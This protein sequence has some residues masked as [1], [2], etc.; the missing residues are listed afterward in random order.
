MQA[1]GLRTRPASVAVLTFVVLVIV[2]PPALAAPGDIDSSF[3]T[4]G[5]V[6]TDFAGFFDIA[7]DALVQGNGRIVAVGSAVFVPQA[8]GQGGTRG[9]PGV[10]SDVAVA[11]YKPNGA[12]DPA[13]GGGDGLVTTDFGGAYDLGSA[14]AVLPS[15]AILV[16]G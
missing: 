12:L 8:P 5:R 9:G 6:R 1:L 10:V 13:F 3:G 7:N 11:R 2:A 14:V 15:G 16:A 4:G